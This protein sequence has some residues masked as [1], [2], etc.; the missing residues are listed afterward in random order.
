LFAPKK[1]L[2]LF[3]S[4]KTV[5]PAQAGAQVRRKATNLGPGLRRDDA[6]L[7]PAKA[8]LHHLARLSTPFF[9]EPHEIA[10]PD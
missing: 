1:A 2:D 5:A 9:S 3:V 7:V 8:A 10:Q 6:E 4:P